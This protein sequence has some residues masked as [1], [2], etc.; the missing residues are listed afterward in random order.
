MEE[1]IDVSGKKLSGISDVNKII[2]EYL[3]DSKKILMNIQSKQ[4]QKD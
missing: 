4:L 3:N 2:P 1:L